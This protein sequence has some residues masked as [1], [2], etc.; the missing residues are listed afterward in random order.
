MTLNTS[1]DIFFDQLKDLNSVED[2]VAGTLPDLVAWA[3]TEP[4]ATV[5]DAH[6]R[7]TERHRQEVKAI[8]VAHGVDPGDDICKAMQG[9]IEGGNK[10]LGMAGNPTVRDLLLV[11]HSSRIAHYAIAAYGFTFAIAESVGFCPEAHGL[12]EIL[13]EQKT[14]LSDL[15]AVGYQVF[16][17]PVGGLK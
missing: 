15:E 12:A 17:V 14:F 13:E 10:H 3:S 2:Q 9:L 11:A 16:G 1:K 5:L 4:L 7:A 8:F 6:R